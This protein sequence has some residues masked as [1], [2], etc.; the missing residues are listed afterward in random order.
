[1]TPTASQ[2]WSRWTPW[3]SFWM[4]SKTMTTAAAKISSASTMPLTFSTFSC[5]Y[6]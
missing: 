1:M 5:P 6:W 4:P 3:M 2:T